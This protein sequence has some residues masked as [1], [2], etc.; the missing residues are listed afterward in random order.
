M[1]LS[2]SVTLG[3]FINKLIIQVVCFSPSLCR[4]YL[5]N[6]NLWDLCVEP[7][8]VVSWHLSLFSVLLV[9]GLFQAVLCAVQVL[10]GLLGALCGG[11]GCCGGVSIY[12]ERSSL[13]SLKSLNQVS[14]AVGKRSRRPVSHR[15]VR[16]TQ[17]R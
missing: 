10:N 14:V 2:G 12:S 4:D 17:E 16:E 1:N 13:C 8:G 5:S 11:C 9:L 15:K 3:S 6:K 7:M